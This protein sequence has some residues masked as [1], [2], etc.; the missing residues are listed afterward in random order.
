MNTFDGRQVVKN[1][2]YPGDASP[3]RQHTDRVLSLGGELQGSAV[4]L[5]CDGAAWDSA[6]SARPLWGS[7]R[8][9]AFPAVCAISAPAW[10]HLQGFAGEARL[11]GRFRRS[12]D[13]LLGEE[14]LA[15]V[16]PEIGPGPFHVVVAA[17]PTAPLPDRAPV[18]VTA[19]ALRFGPWRFTLPPALPLWNPS[20]A[21]AQLAPRPEALARAWGRVR[22]AARVSHS[23]LAGVACGEPLAAVARLGEALTRCDS[24]AT[25]E[26]LAGAVAALAGWGPGLTPSGDDFLAGLMLALWA[27]QGEAA[28][29]LCARIATAAAP[30][31]TRLSG[32]FLRAAAAGLVDARWQRL[33]EALASG[34]L[35]AVDAAT[36]AVLAFGASSGLEMLVGFLWERMGIKDAR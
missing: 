7:Q 2:Y 23:P 15:V 13:W 28:R 6:E 35:E 3:P 18:R 33:L 9:R 21:W 10:A 30:R 5:A 19:H 22:E 34:T 29:P 32:A 26:A 36:Q 17:L 1:T 31:T 25:A 11:L 8:P 14:V 4:V 20:P 16:T 12:V 24:A 27:Q